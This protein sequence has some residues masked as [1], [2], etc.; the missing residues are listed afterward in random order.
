MC[1]S[2]AFPKVVSNS[3]SINFLKEK[4]KQQTS[5]KLFKEIIWTFRFDSLQM[6]HLNTEFYSAVWKV[7]DHEIV[8]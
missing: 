7:S 5:S 4:F 8:E 3:V 2:S 6:S 1:G